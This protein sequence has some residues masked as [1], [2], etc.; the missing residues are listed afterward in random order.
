MIPI[1]S[2]DDFEAMPIGLLVDVSDTPPAPS[3]PSLATPVSALE[4][5]TPQPPQRSRPRSRRR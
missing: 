3:S 5:S 1:E 2:L 4:E